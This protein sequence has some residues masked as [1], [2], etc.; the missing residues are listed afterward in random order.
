MSGT[1]SNIASNCCNT[2]GE[3]INLYGTPIPTG[4]NQGNLSLGMEYDA[5]LWSNMFG[6]NGW[7]EQSGQD[8]INPYNRDQQA[9][10][11]CINFSKKCRPSNYI[12]LAQKGDCCGAVC[13]SVVRSLDILKEVPK[14]TQKTV[15][16]L[17]PTNMCKNSVSPP[18]PL[19]HLWSVYIKPGAC[20]SALPQSDLFRFQVSK[21][22]HSWTTLSDEYLTTAPPPA[23]PSKSI[24]EFLFNIDTPCAQD[25]ECLTCFAPPDKNTGEPQSFPDTNAFWAETGV[26]GH[27]RI[28]CPPNFCFVRIVACTSFCLN[29]F[30]A[31]YASGGG[32]CNNVPLCP[33]GLVYDD[34]VCRPYPVRSC[35]GLPSSGVTGFC[36]PVNPDSAIP[37]GPVDATPYRKHLHNGK[38]LRKHF[39]VKDRHNAQLRQDESQHMR[40]VRAL[41]APPYNS[42][43]TNNG[44]RGT[45][46]N[47]EGFICG[48]CPTDFAPRCGEGCGPDGEFLP[49]GVNCAYP[50]ACRRPYATKH[51]TFDA[52]LSKLVACAV[53]GCRKSGLAS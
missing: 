4:L 9:P 20:D 25:A 2:D 7:W 52:S 38:F 43:A 18:I 36:D 26:A 48:G 30:T 15:T 29:S 17:G 51:Q 45:A 40:N 35:P 23:V 21:N 13:E 12:S 22:G 10:R 46:V 19:R 32:L 37:P 34:K 39:H 41:A 11:N 47:D 42:R 28:A 3:F 6:S 31:T 27:A 33:A 49:R 14:A 5:G 8:V 16:V 53:A 44:S 1:D 50:A 24:Y